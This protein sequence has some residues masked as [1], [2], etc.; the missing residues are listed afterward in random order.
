MLQVELKALRSQL[1]LCESQRREGEAKREEAE[2]KRGEEQGV[3]RPE[4]GGVTQG[5]LQN[6]PATAA[7]LLEGQPSGSSG[8]SPE[9]LQAAVQE[10]VLCICGSSGHSPEACKGLEQGPLTCH[11]LRGPNGAV[12]RSSHP[13]SC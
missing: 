9:A 8:H 11:G 10:L 3:P 2:K 5:D 6:A 7:L 13:K 12:I 4:A 1:Q